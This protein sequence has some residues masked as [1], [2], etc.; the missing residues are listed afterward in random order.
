[1]IP[2]TLE[3]FTA[4]SWYLSLP[5][6]S[7]LPLMHFIC[8]VLQRIDACVIDR[9]K[10]PPYHLQPPFTVTT[11]GYPRHRPRIRVRRLHTHRVHYSIS[12]AARQNLIAVNLQYASSPPA[13]Y[14]EP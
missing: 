3:V 4:R 8:P 1:M 9:S 7:A 10:P 2:A 14:S 12:I 5:L 13:A 11:G 6:V